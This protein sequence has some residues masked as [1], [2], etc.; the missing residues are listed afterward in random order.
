MNKVLLIV[1]MFVSQITMAGVTQRHYSAPMGS[2]E[3]RVSTSRLR[4]GLSLK[5]QDY[6]V[7]YFEQYA[8]KDPHFIISNWQREKHQAKIEVWTMPPNWRR[9]LKPELITTTQAQ[10]SEYLFLL[11]RKSTLHLLSGLMAGYMTRIKYKS[12][13]GQ[14][15]RVDLSPI[16]FKKSYNRYIRCVGN[17]LPFNYLDIQMTK[18]YFN[19]GQDELT[20]LDRQQLDRITLYVSVD[21]TVKAVRVSGYSDNTGRRGFNNAVSEARAKAVAN[22]LLEKGMSDEKLQV[23]WYGMKYPADSNDT[24]IGRAKNRRVVIKVVR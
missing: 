22:Y 1:F 11:H 13:I 17:L 2:E 7:A 14:T 3:W 24:E 5:V 4:C 6:G 9:H 23:T 8:T 12:D 10:F 19:P 18:L 15:V 16:H 21:P 20:V